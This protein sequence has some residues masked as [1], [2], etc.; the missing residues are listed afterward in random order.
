MFS[1]NKRCDKEDDITALH[2]CEVK[3]SA[4]DK[5]YRKL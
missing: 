2:L 4:R 5:A 3:Q 1:Q